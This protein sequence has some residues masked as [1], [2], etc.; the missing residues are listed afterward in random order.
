MPLDDPFF[1]EAEFV[2]PS[3]ALDLQSRGRLPSLS[4]LKQKYSHLLDQNNDVDEEWRKLPIY[5]DEEEITE[6]KKKTDV[7]SWVFLSDVKDVDE[8]PV[9]K[10]LVCLAKLILILPHS[11]AD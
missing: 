1:H 4:L 9:F 8:E 5:F 3:I 6:L 7:E 11:N 10:N 2:Q